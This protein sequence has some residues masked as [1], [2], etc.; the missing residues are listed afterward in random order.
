MS[1]STIGYYD[2]SRDD[3]IQAAQ[4][5]WIKTLTLPLTLHQDMDD[6]FIQRVGVI[7][8]EGHVSFADAFALALAERLN[9]PLVTT[10][11][12]ELIPSSK[13]VASNFTGYA[14]DRSPLER[15]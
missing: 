1:T 8:V 11:H 13:K 5:A 7:K 12:H 4:T 14:R 3:G 2:F 9:V 10:E 15:Q 6:A